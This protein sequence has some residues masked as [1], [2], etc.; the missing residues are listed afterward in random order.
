MDLLPEDIIKELSYYLDLKSIIMMKCVSSTYNIIIG[1]R[2]KL[3]LLS[4]LNSENYTIDELLHLSK[5]ILIKSKVFACNTASY[6]FTGSG[7][8]TTGKDNNLLPNCE[9]PKYV[10]GLHNIIQI[11]SNYQ[12]CMTLTR[13]GYLFTHRH[14]ENGLI[15][16]IS[17]MTNIAHIG[18]IYNYVLILNR[19]GN[20]YWFR[21]GESD[22][23]QLIASNIKQISSKFVISNDGKICEMKLTKDGFELKEILNNNKIISVG[24]QNNIIM[25]L[26]KK[27]K[28]YSID[29]LIN[30]SDEQFKFKLMN[31]VIKF[32]LSDK[33]LLI[34]TKGG[35]LYCSEYRGNFITNPL[36]VIMENIIDMSNEAKHVLILADDEKVYA[37]GDNQYGQ[38]GIGDKINRDEPTFVMDLRK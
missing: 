6:L 24:Y 31:G 32:S 4:N 37:F 9:I 5:T 12:S 30:N 22:A 16:S 38:L 10:P 15:T 19:D 2:C 18:M 35:K 33:F 29:G 34:L 13:D 27:G 26:T 17:A 20:L 11:I 23:R 14:R 3:A 36:K 28:L 7:V 8:Y 1:L 21:M 25:Y